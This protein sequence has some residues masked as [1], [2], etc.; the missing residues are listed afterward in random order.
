M[1]QNWS[2]KAQKK[3]QKM[4]VSHELSEKLPNYQ[5]VFGTEDC[6]KK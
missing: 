2:L 3:V 1:V 4:Q 6:N 5:S